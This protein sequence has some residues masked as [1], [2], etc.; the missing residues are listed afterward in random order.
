MK[1]S[2]STPRS[3]TQDLSRNSPR[4]KPHAPKGDPKPVPTPER[5]DPSHDKTP[6]RDP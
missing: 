5:K 4:E 3:D 2:G 6:R 1:P